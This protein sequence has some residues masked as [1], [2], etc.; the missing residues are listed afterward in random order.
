MLKDNKDE[1]TIG[2]DDGTHQQT[3]ESD[4]MANDAEA[5]GSADVDYYYDEEEVVDDGGEEAAGPQDEDV[6]LAAE[7]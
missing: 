3:V 2:G 1:T 5:A 6:P 4:Q 7:K